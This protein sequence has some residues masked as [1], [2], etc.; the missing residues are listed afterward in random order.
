[1]ARSPSLIQDEKF[2]GERD[3]NGASISKG[4]PGTLSLEESP[5]ALGSN[6]NSSLLY[7][8]L[9]LG[10]EVNKCCALTFY[11]CYQ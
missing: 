5:S 10:I 6:D 11:R 8:F 3:S 7:L 2:V 4:Y 1:M 9:A